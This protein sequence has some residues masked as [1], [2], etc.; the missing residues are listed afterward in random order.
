MPREKPKCRVK[1]CLGKGKSKGK[2]GGIVFYGNLC[3]HHRKKM[4]NDKKLLKS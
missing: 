3:G 4:R 2:R 1:D